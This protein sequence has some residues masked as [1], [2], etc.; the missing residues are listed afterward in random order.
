MKTI[1]TLTPNSTA[2]PVSD[3]HL[4]VTKSRASIEEYRKGLLAESLMA[5]DLIS[6]CGNLY[7]VLSRDICRLTGDTR[8]EWFTSTLYFYCAETN[9]VIER[10][11]DKLICCEKI[12]LSAR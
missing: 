3:A 1:S 8:R 6:W 12:S 9:I 5:G 11:L 10:H 2:K 4:A 7:L